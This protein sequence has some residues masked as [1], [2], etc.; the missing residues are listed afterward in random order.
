MTFLFQSPILLLERS[1]DFQA[2]NIHGQFL[3]IYFSTAALQ[4]PNAFPS[5]HIYFPACIYRQGN[6][7]LLQPHFL[8]K[9][10][11]NSF[12]SQEKRQIVLSSEQHLALPCSWNS[13]F[14][15]TGGHNCTEE[16][17]GSASREL[18][19][20]HPLPKQLLLSLHVPTLKSSTAA[21][22]HPNVSSNKFGLVLYQNRWL[23]CPLIGTPTL[24]YK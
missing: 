19:L 12:S 17:G 4:C 1:S 11:P 8:A 9:L 14:P 10:K 7:F 24:L 15:S 13:P 23:V 6:I 5:A 18:S 16:F 3:L 20:C 2:K 22:S 21:F